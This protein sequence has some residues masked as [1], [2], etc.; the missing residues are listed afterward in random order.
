M[1][2]RVLEAIRESTLKRLEKGGP[3]GR[4]FK[5]QKAQE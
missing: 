2:D 3:M 5:S 4:P 1:R